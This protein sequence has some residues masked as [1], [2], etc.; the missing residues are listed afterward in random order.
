[1]A[2]Y[3]FKGFVTESTVNSLKYGLLCS[4]KSSPPLETAS[5]IPDWV[6]PKGCEEM[7]PEDL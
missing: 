7:D 2:K 1:M 6:L 4:S 5:P 3:N